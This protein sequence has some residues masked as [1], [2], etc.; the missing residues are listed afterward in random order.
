MPTSHSTQLATAKAIG[1]AREAML[2]EWAAWLGRRQASGSLPDQ[3]VARKLELVLDTLI[4]M[5]GPLRREAVLVWRRVMEH[6]GRVGAARGLAAGEIV[7]EI[8]QL[9][10]LLINHI[11]DTIA[12]M[13]PRRSVA[14]F[15][16]L[17]AIIDAGIA[18]A[19]VGYTDALVASLLPDDGREDPLTGADTEAMEDRLAALEAELATITAGR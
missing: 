7:E 19:V 9:R 18:Q 5:L 8:Q 4:A 1:A 14:V 11:G 16:R 12:A 3:L 10:L 13:R 2:V 6:Y 17:N 15:L